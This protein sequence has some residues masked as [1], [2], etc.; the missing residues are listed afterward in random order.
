M[1]ALLEKMKDGTEADAGE[2]DERG[3]EGEGAAE[4][5]EDVAGEPV[6]AVEGVGAAVA[7]GELEDDARLVEEEEGCN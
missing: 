5:A 2:G 3:V 7:H 4:D 6:G 1:V